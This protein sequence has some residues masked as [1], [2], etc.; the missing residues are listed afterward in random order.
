[1][2]LFDVLLGVVP[3]T[4][5]SRHRDGDEDAGD[6]DAEQHGAD[7]GKGI[8]LARDRCDHEVQHDRRQ[9]GQQRRDHHFLDRGLRE[10]VDG[11][12]IIRL[13][14]ARHDAG[15]LLEL[16]ADF[17]DHRLGGT[18]DSQHRHAAEQ[19][20]QATADQQANHHVGVG[21]READGL[22]AEL[23]LVD[24]VVEVRGVGCEQHQRAKAG[25]SDGVALGHGLGGVADGV[26][27]VGVLAYFLGQARHFGNAAGI[28]GDR[29][30]GVERHHHAGERQHGG[31]GDGDAEQAGQDV[32][33][34]DA[35]ADQ[36][37][38][39][40][41]GFHRHREARDDVGA[42][43]SD[44]GLRHRLDRAVVGAGVVL[45]DPHDQACDGET[46]QRAPE[47]RHAGELAVADLEHGTGADHPVG[48]EVDCRDRQHGGRD[49]ALVHGPHDAAVGAEADEIGADD[50]GDDAD[51][52]DGQR[53]DHQLGHQGR[54]G[55][56]ED[57]GQD[58]G[59]DRGHRVGLEQVGRHAGAVADIVADIVGDRGRV[60]RVIFR[61][62]GFYLA[63][64]VAADVGAL[65]E[66]AAAETGEDGDQRGAEAQRNQRVDH[67]AA[68]GRDAGIEQDE[69]VAGDTQQG[70]AR[71]QHAGDSA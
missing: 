47:Q 31:R 8:G 17:L 65:G 57:R 45:G 46:H 5:A 1:M 19:V 9:H 54:I 56:E 3:G 50:R 21:Q 22:D 43:T 39:E 16:P 66:D 7:R 68:A 27:R 33:D 10:H 69:E 62:A 6:D 51:A 44:R 13:F 64:H 38:R 11:A 30:V 35:G 4:A 48:D 14:R 59:G 63:D 60:T 67:V 37:R 36:E 32:A 12:G 58:H 41:R 25:R 40:R 20:R 53:I 61:N 70:E 49:H 18:A 42:M 52:A 55:H 71:H 29:A 28:V 26:E 15:L 24:E 2:A 34:H 23:A